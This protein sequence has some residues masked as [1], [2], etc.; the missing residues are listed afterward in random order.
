MCVT[1]AKIRLTNQ[2][3]TTDA[4]EWVTRLDTVKEYLDALFVQIWD[5]RTA[6]YLEASNARHGRAKNGR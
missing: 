2:I 6:M 1:S 4:E 3:D 5:V